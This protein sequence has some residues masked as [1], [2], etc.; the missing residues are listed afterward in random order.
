MTAEDMNKMAALKLRVRARRE[1]RPVD[2]DMAWDAIAVTQT[3]LEAAGI[4]LKPM[5][6]TA[7]LQIARIELRANGEP[8]LA[9]RTTDN[10]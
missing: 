6:A 3:E 5:A 9:G 8:H 10:G 2:A 7:V 1:S 4:A